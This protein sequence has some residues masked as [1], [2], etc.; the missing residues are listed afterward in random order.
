MGFLSRQ[1]AEY[2]SWFQ[3][4]F[5]LTVHH[6]PRACIR[7][8]AGKTTTSLLTRHRLQALGKEQLSQ[9]LRIQEF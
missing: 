2:R 3:M 4:V 6:I 1:G 7:V 9:E 5:L 8:D